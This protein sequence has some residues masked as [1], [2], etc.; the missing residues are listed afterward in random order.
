MNFNYKKLY[1]F[2][3]K[4]IDWYRRLSFNINTFNSGFNS[5]YFNKYVDYDTKLQ[6][7]S[8]IKFDLYAI[9]YDI[10]PLQS[11][12]EKIDILT[13][14]IYIIKD[15]H[16]DLLSVKD[17]RAQEVNEFI[18][19]HKP[20]DLLAVNW[21]WGN[22]DPDGDSSEILWIDIFNDCLSHFS[23]CIKYCIADLNYLKSKLLIDSTVTPPKV[24]TSNISYQSIKSS[25]DVLQG[26]FLFTKTCPY[27]TYKGLFS[28]DHFRS[29]IIWHGKKRTLRYFVNCLSKS[30]KVESSN[31][32]QR[33]SECFRI[34][35][36][37]S[38]SFDSFSNT[39]IS[40]NWVKTIDSYSKDII[41]ESIVFI[42]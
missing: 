9:K 36:K 20:E 12:N 13:K 10:I 14:H 2:I 6:E 1:Y 34:L 15:L 42:S 32:W 24:F 27:K 21:V 30:E 29:P 18:S 40:R 5:L 41:D 16:K 22:G 37:N 33:A 31:K 11:Q 39:D 23:Q 17:N 38:N 28:A 35:N 7:Y 8:R 25:Y 3:E 26:N 4:D 19:Q